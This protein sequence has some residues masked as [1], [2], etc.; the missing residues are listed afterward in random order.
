[1][2]KEKEGLVKIELNKPSNLNLEELINPEFPF[3][4]PIRKDDGT[5]SH[6]MTTGKKILKHLPALYYF[7]HMLL[8]RQYSDLDFLR[9]IYD[10]R[11]VKMFSRDIE[12]VKSKND[13]RFIW[14]ILR[15]IHVI[16]EDSRNEPTKYRKSAMGYYFKLSDKYIDS[17]IIEHEIEIKKSIKDKLDDKWNLKSKKEFNLS[18]IK[19]NRV[20]AHQYQ[21]LRNINIDYEAAMNH[22]K[23]LIESNEIN[24]QQYNTCMIYLNNIKNGRIYITKSD[25]CNRYYTPITNLPKIVRPFIKDNAGNSLVELDYGSFNAFVVYKILNSIEPQ[26]QN[27]AEKIAFETELELY[28]RTLSGG[29]FYMDFK[30]IFFTDKNI[31]REKIKDIV[32]KYWFNGKLNS[33]NKYRKVLLQRLPKISEIIDSLKS[34]KYEN[35]SHI[36]M[37]ME[38]ELINE[39]VYKKFIDLHPDVIMYTIFDSILVEQKYASQLQTMMLEEGS[40]YFNLNCFVNHK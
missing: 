39:I 23:N 31:D 18:E 2:V 35:F 24:F 16:E 30:R 33:R 38:S 36:T 28:R 12:P 32:L 19:T 1:M 40:Q 8:E 7:I 11:F 13:F 37:T 6:K 9:L 29:N 17:P 20:S 3:F 21:L 34:V 5:S 10:K 26:Y 4:A 14:G 27:N 25:K 22:L 15:A